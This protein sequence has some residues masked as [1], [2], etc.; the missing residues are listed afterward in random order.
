MSVSTYVENTD[1]LEN[2]IFIRVNGVQKYPDRLIPIL[3]SIATE[4]PK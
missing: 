1:K 3:C 4:T 2:P